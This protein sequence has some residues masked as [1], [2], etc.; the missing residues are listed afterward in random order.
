MCVCVC[1]RKGLYC[2]GLEKLS[3][4]WKGVSEG[5]GHGVINLMYGA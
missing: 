2:F 3:L 5:R 1:V 4:F